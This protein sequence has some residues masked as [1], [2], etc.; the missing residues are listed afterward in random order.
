MAEICYHGNRGY[1]APPAESAQFHK[2][3]P[4]GLSEGF[5]NAPAFP[6]AVCPVVACPRWIRLPERE[7]LLNVA[8][9]SLF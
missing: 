4:G 5:D 1:D 3:K 8:T 6:A 7:K 9:Q 2:N